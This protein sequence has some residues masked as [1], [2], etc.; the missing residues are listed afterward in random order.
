MLKNKDIKNTIRESLG[1]NLNESYVATSKK[2]EIKTENLTVENKEAHLKLYEGYVAAFNQSSAQLDTVDRDAA[3]VNLSQFRDLKRAETYNLNAV[4]L[5]EFFFANI[6]KV[7][8]S[9][10]TDSL[11]Y[12]RLSRD[13]GDFEKW[14]D[15]FLA[16]ALSAR[17]GWVITAFNTFLRRYVNL[18]IDS[19]DI[20]VMMGC[21]PVIVIDMWSH[22]YYKDYL[23]DKD[24][25]VRKMMGELNW[26][27]IE[28][29]IARAD[30][31]G[32]ALS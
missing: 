3:N 13:F 18:V 30:K 25:Y 1:L 5:H 32:E 11:A 27:T 19:H 7:E 17:E 10:H 9:L 23:S 29:R 2:F 15:D 24:K 4:Y 20:N 26:D 12:M 28:N 22:T 8:S 6:G 16:C 31:I 21:Y 14:Q